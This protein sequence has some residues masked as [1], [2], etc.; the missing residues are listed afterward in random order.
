[1]QRTVRETVKQFYCK[2]IIFIYRIKLA[3]ISA[4]RTPVIE[5]LN[6]NYGSIVF[7][8]KIYFIDY[9]KYH[10]ISIDIFPHKFVQAVNT[11]CARPLY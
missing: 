9:I 1:M 6:A 8:S 5:V 2:P 10:K 4:P 3:E 7:Y 11:L